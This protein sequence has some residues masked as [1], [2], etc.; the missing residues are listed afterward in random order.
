[1]KVLQVNCVYAT[2]STGRLTEAIHTHLLSDGEKSVVCYGRG[3][4]SNKEGVYKICNELYAKVQ[5]AM[6]NI[7]GIMYGGCWSST[8]RLISI[9]RKEK[10]DIV[11]LQCINGYFV[12]IYRL[13]DWLKK[14]EVKTVLTLHADFMFTANCGTAVDCDKWLIG[15]G[16]C[17][18]LRKET[19]SLFY[20]RTALSWN[21]MREA[22]YGFEKNCT[23]V[24]VSPWLRKRAEKAP[25]LE[26]FRHV[27][28]E[29]GVDTK[30]FTLADAKDLRQKY[31]FEGRKLVL[32][33]TASF[34]LEHGSLKG[35]WY[36]IELAKR[37]ADVTFVVIGN[38]TPANNLPDNVL[39]IGRTENQHE[40]AAWYCA[41]D[42]TVLTSHR[43]TF[44][45]V[46]A[47]SLCCGTPVVGF[48]A[49]GP[50][51]IA[52]PSCSEFVEYGDLDAL[53]NALRSKLETMSERSAIAAIASAKFSMEN[54]YYAYHDEYKALLHDYL[55]VEAKQDNML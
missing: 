52:P 18:R 48:R 29:N 28:I 49:G 47:E 23:V 24:S 41:A 27:T 39:C 53:E 25:I 7:T 42:A 31:D 35:G 16:N 34:S 5:H 6:A 40:L 32:H 30:N 45:M 22:F 46:T 50:E 33:V 54:M 3:R 36:I 14:N 12:N 10:P 17:P 13:I 44:S 38:G 43:E 9:I 21:K 2:G 8:Q 37:I 1:M 55:L 26:N 20:D 51:S 15:C 19:G 11:H 4:V